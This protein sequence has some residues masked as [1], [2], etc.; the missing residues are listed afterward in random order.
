MPPGVSFTGMSH[1][2][3]VCQSCSG[4][5]PILLACQK[6]PVPKP[7][8]SMVNKWQTTITELLWNPVTVPIALASKPSYNAE[9]I[10]KVLEEK[11][12]NALSVERCNPIS[13]KFNPSPKN[14]ILY[15]SNIHCE[16]V[17]A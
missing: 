10:V 1:H 7:A 15:S 11:I 5:C 3:K 12:K 8:L 14:P 9:D 2:S 16:A 13:H 4:T 17:L 6:Y